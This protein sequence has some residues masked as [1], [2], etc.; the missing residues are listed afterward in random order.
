MMIL[1]AGT[2]REKGLFPNRRIFRRT[3]SGNRIVRWGRSADGGRL[4]MTYGSRS[5]RRLPALHAGCREFESLIAHLKSLVIKAA[6]YTE[7]RPRP[8]KS[9]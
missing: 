4:E 8:Q 6:V 1:A 9:R 2:L 5:L 7:I 3:D